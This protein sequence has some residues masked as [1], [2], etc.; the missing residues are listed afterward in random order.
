MLIEGEYQCC[1]RQDETGQNIRK[2]LSGQYHNHK[3]CKFN[4]GYNKK[5]IAC[6]W[7][8]LAA[9]PRTTFIKLEQLGRGLGVPF[10]V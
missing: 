2:K 9:E 5:D 6:I 10:L 1:K 3:R 7:D 8:D 4:S